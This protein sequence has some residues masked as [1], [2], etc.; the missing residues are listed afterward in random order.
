MK[1]LK[2]IKFKINHNSQ[3]V[4]VNNGSNYRLIYNGND[5]FWKIDSIDEKELC[6]VRYSTIR[7]ALRDKDAVSKLDISSYS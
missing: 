6:P 3:Y 2:N 4:I 1:K 5:V 7:E